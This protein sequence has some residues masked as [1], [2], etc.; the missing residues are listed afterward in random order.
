MLRVDYNQWA[1]A[2][3]MLRQLATTAEHARTRERFRELYEVMQAQCATDADELAIELMPLPAYSVPASCQLKR[4][5]AGHPAKLNRF[6]SS[7]SD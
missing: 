2:T 5:G 3:E 4:C 7:R 1:Q 6:S